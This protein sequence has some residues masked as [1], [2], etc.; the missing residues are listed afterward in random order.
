MD[1]YKDVKKDPPVYNLED[2]FYSIYPEFRSKLGWK[3][4]SAYR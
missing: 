4:W 2:H 1:V 3:E